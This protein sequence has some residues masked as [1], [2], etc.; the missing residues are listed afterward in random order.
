MKHLPSRLKSALVAVAIVISSIPMSS[1]ASTSLASQ[2]AGMILLQVEQNGEAWYVDPATLTRYSLGR[3]DDAFDVMRSLGLGISNADLAL[4]PVAGSGSA[5]GASMRS[6]L[7]GTILLQVESL[8][9]AWYVYPETLERTYL[10]RPADALATM[11]SLGL[12]ISDAN[13]GTIPVAGTP[14]TA[15]ATASNSSIKDASHIEKTVTTSRGSFTIDLVTIPRESYEMVTDTAET[16][17]CENG[18]ATKTLADFVAE[19]GGTI[20][21]HG[22]YFCPSDYSSCS[23]MTATFD[24]PVYNTA[25]GRM[26]NEFDLPYHS[27]PMLTT[28]EDGTL[29]FYHRATDFGTSVASYESTSGKQLQSAIAN[30]PSLV[31]GGANIVASEVVNSSQST[32][33]S[34]GGI[35]FDGENFYLVIAHSASVTDLAAIFDEAI[36]A[37]Y[38]M[39]LDGGATSA[40]YFEGSYAYGPSRTLANAIV[41]RSR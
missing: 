8:G 21:I 25:A 40:L 11:S 39:N 37:D 28:N 26:L 30:Y 13:L 2:T 17:D 4:I 12:G 33:S 6:R 20:G 36:G 5:G 9:E 31:E 27:G 16:D 19:N 34:R 41:F 18:C 38:A 22:T 24:P 32:K 1:S 14:S 7:S 35:G 10:G 23:G 3:P 15:I 29:W